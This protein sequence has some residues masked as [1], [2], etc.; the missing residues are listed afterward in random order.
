MRHALSGEL[1]LVPF[2]FLFCGLLLIN[3]YSQPI[4]FDFGAERNDHTLISG[5][6]NGDELSP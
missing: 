4:P 1:D 3:I 6:F 5:S 2:F